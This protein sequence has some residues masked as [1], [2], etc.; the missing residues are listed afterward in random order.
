MIKTKYDINKNN[1]KILKKQL[2]EKNYD[3]EQMKKILVSNNQQISFLNTIK[4]SSSKMTKDNEEL[5]QQLKDTICNLNQ[6][7]VESNEKINYLKQQNQN[8]KAQKIKEENESLKIYLNDRE[9][10]II[11]LKNSI[12]LFT[13]NLDNVINN[14]NIIKDINTERNEENEK[15]IN[16]CELKINVLKEKSEKMQ[17]TIDELSYENK[18]KE[19][20]NKELKIKVNEI[21]EKYERIRNN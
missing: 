20:E 19:K 17:K 7:I 12:S 16:N 11:N 2:D 21:L 5:I 8:D 4:D 15:I 13:Q 6:I 14:N 1:I 9:K 18:N 3:I 10:T